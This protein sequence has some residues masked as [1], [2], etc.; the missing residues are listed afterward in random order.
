LAVAWTP[1]VAVLT[2]TDVGQWAAVRIGSATALVILSL[3]LLRP[4]FLEKDSAKAWMICSTILGLAVLAA[5]SA[6]SHARDA[7]RAVPLA[8]ASDWLHL[9][10][11]VIWIGGLTHLLMA[12]AISR[13]RDSAS[14]EFL[15]ILAP[16]FSRA[17]QLCVVALAATG[18]YNTWLHV[19]SW[20]SFVS[21]PYGQVLTTKIGL[22]LA[23]L[24][25]GAINWKKALPAMAALANAP[26]GAIR[27]SVKLRQL[28]R[29]EVVLGALILAAVGLL[30]NLPPAT[31]SSQGGKT[32]LQTK[33]GENVLTLRVEPGKV[34]KNQAI[35]WLQ[36]A[37]GREISDARNVTLFVESLDMDMGMETVS[38]SPSPDGKYQAELLLSMAGKWKI[39]VEVSP[40][41]GDTFDAEFQIMSAP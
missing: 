26:E 2:T 5:T 28:V 11:T 18:I 40:A 10:A 3:R 7:G 25:V 24:L 13:R 4:G 38:A 6:T 36:D 39:T 29:A 23:I 41:R 33:V 37:S 1:I 27:W 8:L 15:N 16:R 22:F 12:L 14:V 9:V 35:L 31:A 34:G 19:P 21:S 20:G 32:N 17:A 30:T